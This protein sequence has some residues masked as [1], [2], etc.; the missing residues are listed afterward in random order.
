MGGRSCATLLYSELVRTGDAGQPIFRRDQT[1]APPPIRL[2]GGKTGILANGGPDWQW[3]MMGGS[4]LAVWCWAMHSIHEHEESPGISRIPAN[5]LQNTL[6]LKT[7]KH[8]VGR[9]P[10][11]S[12]HQI[13]RVCS[14][15]L[16]IIF[17]SEV[18]GSHLKF[19]KRFG[20]FG[21]NDL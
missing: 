20:A 1:D 3:L 19:R 8:F 6:V 11:G 7:L 5:E 16:E 9:A 2:A 15:N 4:A 13:H 18:D 17:R 14:L 12:C 21:P 10:S